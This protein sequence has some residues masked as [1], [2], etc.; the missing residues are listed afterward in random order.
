MPP[1]ASL[2]V[3]PTRPCPSRTVVR[4]GLLSA[5]A[6]VSATADGNSQ[7]VTGVLM[8]AA[9]GTPIVSALVRL[10]HPDGRI[11]EQVLTDATGRFRVTPD[12]GRY[13]VV[14]RNI[15]HEDAR[16]GPFD[17]D[18]GETRALTLE[19]RPSPLRVQGVTANVDRRCRTLDD[20][21]AAL[22]EAFWDEASKALEAARFTDAQGGLSYQ[23]THF[24]RELDPKDLSVESEE[25]QT[26]SGE[27]ARP[28]RSLPAEVLAR[29]GYVQGVVASGREYFAPDAEVLLSDLFVDSHCFRLGLD[30]GPRGIPLEFAPLDDPEVVD[31]SGTLWLDAGSFELYR[32]EFGYVGL[33]LGVS[34]ENI[35]GYVDFEALESGAWIVRDWSIRMPRLRLLSVGDKVFRDLAG[36]L[37][38]GGRVERV[39]DAQGRPLRA[40]D[41]GPER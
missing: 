17:L 11:A 8:D 38:V 22:V 5:A 18:T 26:R 33:A 34:D 1:V 19:A 32:L 37:E 2:F 14:T 9:S 30:I 13:V 23:V 12:P 15:G 31:V 28:F 40:R 20:R 16:A 36:I 39:T 21:D 41:P 7:T 10:E 4:A 24:T 27:G 35:G 25:T 29:D 3:S 6:L